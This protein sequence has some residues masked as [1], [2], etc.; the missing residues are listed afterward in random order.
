LL[1]LVVILAIPLVGLF[2]YVL[3]DATRTGRA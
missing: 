2:V 3:W 1:W